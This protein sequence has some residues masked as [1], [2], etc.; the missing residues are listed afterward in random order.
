M[1]CPECGKR[2]TTWR[3]GYPESKVLLVHTSEYFGRKIPNR[4]LEGCMIDAKLF[5]KIMKSEE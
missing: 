1:K 4:E 5:E 2:V 3:I